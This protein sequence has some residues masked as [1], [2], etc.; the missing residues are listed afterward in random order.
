MR[1]I[2]KK[3]HLDNKILQTKYFYFVFNTILHGVAS[4]NLIVTFEHRFHESKKSFC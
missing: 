4:A 3:N 1:N 2:F